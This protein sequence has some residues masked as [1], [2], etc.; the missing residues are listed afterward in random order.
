VA[1]P[2]GWRSPLA[3]WRLDA[4]AAARFGRGRVP[5]VLRP[6]D[7][8]WRRLAPGFATARRLAA[9]GLPF[10]VVAD[11]AVDRRADPQRLGRALAAGATV[12]YPQIHQ[13]LPRVARLVAALRGAGFGGRREEASFLFLVDGRGRPGLGLHHDGAVDGVWLQLE[14]RRTVTVGPPVAPG[15]PEDLDDRLAPADPRAAAP[16][17]WRTLAL[18]PGTLFHLPPHTPHRVV[19]HGRSLAITLTWGPRRRGGRAG[20][21]ARA[22]WDVISGWADAVPPA[23]RTRLWTQVPI[24]AGP[25]DARRGDFALWTPHGV[26]RLPARAHAVCRR[27]AGLPHGPAAALPPAVRRLLLAHGILAPRELPLWLRPARPAALDGWR[28]A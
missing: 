5:V 25:V 21:A 14:G 13:V 19:C 23:S 18:G 2:E 28:F 16:A 24:A 4:R 27:L 15:T 7:A 20:A 12:Y 9:A 17:G 22:D 1:V 3:T 11:R 10:H 6:R 8:G 26:L